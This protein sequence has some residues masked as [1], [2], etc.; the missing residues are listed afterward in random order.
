MTHAS[1]RTFVTLMLLGASTTSAVAG[2]VWIAGRQQARIVA[3]ATR[4]A[5]TAAEAKQLELEQERI[6]RDRGLA[7][8][9]GTISASEA[10]RL[11]AERRAASRH[12]AE[13]SHNGLREPR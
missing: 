12:I 6:A 4:G 10:H 7:A 13:L 5:L 3:G 2:P 8:S 11:T 1:L 9:D